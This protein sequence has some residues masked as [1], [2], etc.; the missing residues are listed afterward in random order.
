MTKYVITNPVNPELDINSQEDAHNYN[1]KVSKLNIPDFSKELNNVLAAKHNLD[2]THSNLLGID[3]GKIA[4]CINDKISIIIGHAFGHD[5]VQNFPGGMKSFFKLVSDIEIQ[6]SQ[7]Q[8]QL[9]PEEQG[10]EVLR[11]IR[12]YLIR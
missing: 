5:N 7:L 6:L 4:M 3:K 12:P 9:S 8:L 10:T 1:V 11:G 2:P